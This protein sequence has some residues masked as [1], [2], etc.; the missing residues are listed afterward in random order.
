MRKS[1]LAGMVLSLIGVSTPAVIGGVASA[2][3][4]GPAPAISADPSTNLLNGQQ[5]TVTGTH[6]DSSDLGLVECTSG[7]TS[8][9]D[10]DFSTLTIV[11][12]S[13][14]GSFSTPFTAIRIIM[15]GTSPVDCAGA[16]ACVLGAILESGTVLA[17]TPISFQDVTIVPPTLTATP[18][19]NLL[20]GQSITVSGANYN[21]DEPVAIVECQAGATSV[22]GCDPTTLQA[23]TADQ[24]GS[25][26]GP[27]E[28]T[29]V[30]NPSGTP[31]DCAG[32]DA[33]VLASLDENFDI[34][35][36]AP[37]AFKD[38]PIP[39]PVLSATPDTALVDGQN[40][41]VRGAHF[42]PG[43]Q[44]VL[45]ECQ[46]KTHACGY[47]GVVGGEQFATVDSSG[48]FTV[49]FNA[50]RVLVLLGATVDCAKAPGCTLNAIDESSLFP[51]TLARTPL[52]FNP[53]VPPLPPLDL[54]VQL[55]PTGHIVPGTTPTS[56]GVKLR[57]T[58]ACNRTMPTP[59][60]VQFEVSQAGP[61]HSQTATEF[62]GQA[63]CQIGGMPFDAVAQ[64]PF[65]IPTFPFVPGLA[66]AIYEVIG[67]SGS[68]ASEV[69]ITGAV[70]LVAAK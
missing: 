62:V 65:D 7:A 5:I 52:S 8:S 40:I 56:N 10:C 54:K 45:T 21:P 41:T 70:N 58:V 15:P 38:I 13:K 28:V 17:T 60:D 33:C 30:I 39:T 31:I 19:T 36:T 55:D 23:V 24:T 2:T 14:N 32:A 9:Q 49:T 50:S 64:M 44:I 66:S 3:P 16:G 63:M 48:H 25:I 42:H 61:H 12:P 69:A 57:A 18:S 20:D 26:S 43:E 68:A 51:T 37:I 6:F 4:A 47:D 1:L 59:V 27:Y 34:L 53:A 67:T 29:R 11:S 46:R 35:A 22:G